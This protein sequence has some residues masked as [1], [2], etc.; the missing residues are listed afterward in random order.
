MS[1]RRKRLAQSGQPPTGAE[2]SGLALLLS[3]M[4]VETLDLHGL[5]ADEAETRVVFFVE[6]HRTTS[7]G[8]VVHVITGKGTGSAG[9]A[10]LPGLVREIL[11]YDLA[12]LVAEFGGLPGGGGYAV[13]VSGE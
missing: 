13:R 7:P 1:K 3:E 12:K 2:L 10:V 5:T 4:P 6:R 11:M 8:R 9:E